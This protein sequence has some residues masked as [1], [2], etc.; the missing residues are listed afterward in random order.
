M[1]L[2]L[3]KQPK[4]FGM[5]VKKLDN[6]IIFINIKSKMNMNQGHKTPNILR[7]KNNS[8]SGYEFKSYKSLDLEKNNSSESP[9]KKHHKSQSFFTLNG[10]SF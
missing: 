9:I 6:Y 1:I 7:V 8:I 3:K 2:K 10:N 4:E 5:K